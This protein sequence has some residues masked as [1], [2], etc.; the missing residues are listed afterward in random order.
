VKKLFA[1]EMPYIHATQQTFL[2][3]KKSITNCDEQ[4]STYPPAIADKVQTYPTLDFGAAL[5]F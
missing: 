4:E 1:N 2:L 3:T 5:K